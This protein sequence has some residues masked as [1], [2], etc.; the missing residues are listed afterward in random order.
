[1]AAPIK[2]RLG[3]RH[4]HAAALAPRI[5]ILIVQI[6]RENLDLMSDDENENPTRISMFAPTDRPLEDDDGY[7]RVLRERRRRHFTRLCVEQL[8][9]FEEA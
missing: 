6:H 8:Y 5:R 2:R 7:E 4:K 9:R 3:R 1:M